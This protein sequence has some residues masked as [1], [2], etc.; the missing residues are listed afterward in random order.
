MRNT[1]SVTE[2]KERSGRYGDR[3]RLNTYIMATQDRELERMCQV[4]GMS[5]TD[6]IIEALQ[7]WINAQRQ[8]G[9]L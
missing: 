2:V 6:A 9:V 8:L 5:K 1:K 4:T 7:Y 3:V